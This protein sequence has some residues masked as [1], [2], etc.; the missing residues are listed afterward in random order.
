MVSPMADAQ[1]LPKEPNIKL[2]TLDPGHFHAA[3]VQKNSYSTVSPIVH[4]YAPQTPDVTLH[5]ER[6][7]PQIGKKNC[8][9]A[10]IILKKCSKKK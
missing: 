2:I 4:V 8:T 5:L 6:I 9:R 10:K 7:N 1:S 3:L